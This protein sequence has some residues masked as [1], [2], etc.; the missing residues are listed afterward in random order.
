MREAKVYA[1]QHEQGMAIYVAKNDAC[2]FVMLHRANNPLF[3]H[4]RDKGK[5][6]RSLKDYR[7]GRNR[8][9]Q[10]LNRSIKHIVKMVELVLAE[11]YAIA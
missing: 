8:A 11:Q 1:R 10:Q 7:P 4:L 9:E 5:S 6:L 2:S 3:F